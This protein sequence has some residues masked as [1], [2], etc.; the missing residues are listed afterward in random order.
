VGDVLGVSEI[1]ARV[2]VHRALM[3]LRG[4]LGPDSVAREVPA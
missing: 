2:R 4:Q 3:K 1:A